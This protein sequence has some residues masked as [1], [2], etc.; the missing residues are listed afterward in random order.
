MTVES[1]LEPL[2][3][4]LARWHA[5]GLATSFGATSTVAVSIFL[6]RMELGLMQR[7]A[8]PTSAPFAACKAGIMRVAVVGVMDLARVTA[9]VPVLPDGGVPADV[10][11]LACSWAQ[12]FKA[13]YALPREM[14]FKSVA[15][16][17]RPRPGWSPDPCL[18]ACARW[19]QKGLQ[20]RRG[21]WPA[22]AR[23]SWRSFSTS[24]FAM[25]FSLSWTPLRCVALAVADRW[26]LA[27]HSC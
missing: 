2:V 22:V 9:A 21:Q 8:V 11:D 6:V 20:C 1:R 15:A 16:A 7:A 14:S 19:L 18:M 26:L 3:A 23:S 12:L 4:G 27:G 13:N 25:V 24:C 5:E 17:A 10:A